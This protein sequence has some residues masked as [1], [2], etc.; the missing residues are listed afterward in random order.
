MATQADL[1]YE[2]KL[3]A[4]GRRFVG[5]LDEVGRGAWAGPLF[6]GVVVVDAATGP[7]PE[8]TRDSK[9][10]SRDARR[11]LSA[12]LETWCTAWSLG[13][14]SAREIDALGLTSA[15]RLAAQRALRGLPELPQALIVDGPVDFVSSAERSDGGEAVTELSVHPVV[16][17]DATCATV[18]AASVLAKLA[19]DGRM[20][21]L[22][23]RFPGYGFEQH[24]G[25]GT[26]AHA[27]EISVR[28]LCAQ[29]RKTWSFA[30]SLDATTGPIAP[31]CR[32]G[33]KEMRGADTPAEIH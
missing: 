32:T 30:A 14:A 21:A 23:R 10:L 19:R 12:H 24:K 3:L 29:H 16:G 1:S 9:A 22:A 15:L 31:P 2:S 33:C 4:A 25:Y 5:G 17:A 26:A 7:P 6:V 18:A 28:G 11:R 20:T 13:E 27:E 8:G